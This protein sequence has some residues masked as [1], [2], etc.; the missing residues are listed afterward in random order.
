M[1]ARA[2]SFPSLSPWE[3]S[4]GMCKALAVDCF[5]RALE[6]YETGSSLNTGWWISQHSYDSE[7]T[8]FS[9]ED[10]PLQ[11]KVTSNIELEFWSAVV[12]TIKIQTGVC[13]CLGEQFT[14]SMQDY[15]CSKESPM[16]LFACG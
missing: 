14:Q 5:D 15:S 4:H 9:K 3:S 2:A 11:W 1:V 10:F 8:P 12:G 13:I 6:S 16:G 7:T